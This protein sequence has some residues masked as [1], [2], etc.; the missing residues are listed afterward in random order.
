[1]KYR[2]GLLFILTLMLISVKTYPIDV[3][4]DIGAKL[5]TSF[6]NGAYL[7]DQGLLNLHM[8]HE[9]DNDIYGFAQFGLRYSMHAQNAVTLDSILYPSDLERLSGIQP[10][11]ISLDELYFQY[12]GFIF[13]DLDLSLG[14]QRISWG[15]ADQF[16]PND[17]LNP[18]DLIDPYDYSRRISVTSL[19]LQ[20]YLPFLDSNLHFVYEPISQVARMNP[21]AMDQLYEQVENNFLE[22][23]EESAS[24]FT[25][26]TTGW[27]SVTVLSPSASLTN[28]LY[29][30]KYSMYVGGFDISLSL[31][32]RIHDF[33]TVVQ[34]NSSQTVNLGM[35]VIADVTADMTVVN[36]TTIHTNSITTNSITTNIHS[37]NI[38][39]ESRSFALGYGKEWGV[40][41][42][43][44]KDF[45][46][47]LFW[48]EFGLFFP[49][50]IDA[51]ANIDAN[52]FV[53]ADVTAYATAYVESTTWPYGTTN[54][55]TNYIT[56]ELSIE[57]NV[58]EHI[59]QT[60]TVLN[61][62]PYLKFTL[63]LDKFFGKGWYLNFQY[64]HGLFNERGTEGLNRL[65]DYFVLY[66]E[67][68]FAEKFKL[69]LA[70][71]YNLN[72]IKA[73]FTA[74]DTGEYIKQNSAMMELLRFDYNPSMNMMLSIGTA[75]I[76]GSGGS[77]GL[78]NDQ[79]YIFGEVKYS[80]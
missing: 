7:F 68:T 13:D 15:V 80:F 76:F 49:D 40:G 51:V 62:K 61:N 44:V 37:T 55:S 9:I 21:F 70:T 30:L 23:M 52:S 38:V 29:G 67:K 77:I 59:S 72:N 56:N 35:D 14:K 78:L 32:R 6:S 11:E 10:L 12:Y 73:A 8:D 69:S 1:M 53:H 41:L 63:G 48:A 39:L 17:V 34:F 46:I 20:Y 42:D 60:E 79:D 2:F 50:R 75:V 24:G 36:L 74:D 47:F 31:T 43:L 4:G 19:S 54:Y 58:L 33:P 64:A 45:G 25:N 26:N 65:Q 66:I 27:D 71:T 5:S 16:R 18:V 3:Y 22:S 28:S 57:T